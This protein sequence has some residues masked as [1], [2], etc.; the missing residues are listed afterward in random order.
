M[1]DWAIV[2]VAALVCAT[3]ILSVA[4]LTGVGQPKQPKKDD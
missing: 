3:V 4:M 2:T 1:A